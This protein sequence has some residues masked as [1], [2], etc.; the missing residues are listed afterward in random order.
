MHWLTQPFQSPFSATTTPRQWKPNNKVLLPHPSVGPDDAKGVPDSLSSVQSPCGRLVHHIWLR[1][2]DGQVDHHGD[3]GRWKSCT[4][5]ISYNSVRFSGY[6]CTQESPFTL[7]PVLQKFPRKAHSL[8]PVLQK[9]PRKA[10]S[11][12]PVLQKFPRKAHSHSTLSCRSSPGKP[13]HTPPCPAEVPQESPFTP[14]CPAEVPQESPFTPPCPA[15]VPQESPF[16]LHPVLQKF[17]RKAHS[18]H[19]VLQKFPRKAHS[20]HPVLQKFPRK[21]HSHSTL[22]CRS[23]PR[24][25]LHTPPCPAEV[26]QESPSHST[27]SCRSSPSIPI[28]TAPVL[29]W[30]LMAQLHDTLDCLRQKPSVSFILGDSNW[31]FFQVGYPTDYCIQINIVCRT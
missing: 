11:L 2:L 28:K 27:L 15:E 1:D 14:P 21:A 23:S 5:C 10:H 8:H 30:W 18:L 9:F 24:K 22:S 26:P 25:A 13:I 16:T 17:P 7:H 12:H 4:K 31:I 20:L 19:P 6:L 29:I 3:W